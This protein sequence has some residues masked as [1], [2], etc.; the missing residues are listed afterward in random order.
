MNTLLMTIP[1][2]P[3]ELS[4]FRRR[5]RTWLVASELPEDL[6]DETIIAVHEA[7]ATTIE[8]GPAE[9]TIAIRA[10]LEDRVI[11]V[12]ITGGQWAPPE[13]DEARRLSL[14]QRLVED[15]DIHPDATG[16]TIR[17]RQSV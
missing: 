1:A 10:S 9:T 11:A 4:G 2:D 5:F 16:T 12:E 8:H 17:L 13:I 7:M 14:I 3:G 6:Q 15:V